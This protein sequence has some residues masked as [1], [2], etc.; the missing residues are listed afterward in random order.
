MSFAKSRGLPVLKHHLFPHTRGFS[1][2]L[3]AMKD[4]GQ[5]F[6][7]YVRIYIRITCTYAH[8]HIIVHAMHGSTGVSSLLWTCILIMEGSI[9]YQRLIC[10][11]MYIIGTSETV[12]IREVSLFQRLIFTQTYTNVYVHVNACVCVCVCVCVCACLCVCVC[13]YT[14]THITYTYPHICTYVRICTH[15]PCSV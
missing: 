7:T 6:C 4:V 15:S 8:F 1:C 2:V 3:R 10:A 9:L 12:L 5:L 11:R 13:M 14:H